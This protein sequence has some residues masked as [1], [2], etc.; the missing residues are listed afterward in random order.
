M[1]SFG[2]SSSQVVTSKSEHWHKGDTRN[3]KRMFKLNSRPSGNYF[4]N[5][6]E[7][8]ILQIKLTSIFSF[9]DICPHICL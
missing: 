3:L 5:D 9:R 2:S 4:L 1:K 6:A 8:F 7:N